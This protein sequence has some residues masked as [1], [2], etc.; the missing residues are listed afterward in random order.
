M[1]KKNTYIIISIIIMIIGIIMPISTNIYKSANLEYTTANYNTTPIGEIVKD[2]TVK[3][4]IEV[5]ERLKKYG[6][7]FAT[8]ARKNS[9][10]IKITLNQ[11]ENIIEEIV[12]ISKIKDNSTYYLKSD[13]SKLHKGKAIIEIRGIDG[14]EGNAVTIYKSEDISLGKLSF[15]G[16]E[17]NNGIVQS[18]K[19][20][21]IDKNTI[22][23]IVFAV[24]CIMCCFYIIYLCNANKKTNKLF[25]LTAICIFC[26]L[27]IKIPIL[28]FNCEPYA[29]IVTNFYINGTTKDIL[30]N[31]FI[32]DAGYLPLF[33]RIISLII[34]KVLRLSPSHTIYL[35]QNFAIIAISL[36]SSMFTLKYYEKYGDILFRFSI[37]IIIG[38]CALVNYY[39][40]HS[41]IN[42]SYYGI[43]F[44][45]LISLLDLNNIE[46]KKYILVIVLTAL[47]SISK[48]HYVV[49]L[50]IVVFVLIWKRGRISNRYKLFLLDIFLANVIQL[51]YTY[52]NLNMWVKPNTN[53]I[54]ISIIDIINN[55]VHQVVQQL[56][57]IFYPNIA[58]INNIIEM[59]LTFLVILV[60]F[61]L[62]TLCLCIKF[63]K[64]ESA[65][66]ISLMLMIFGTTMF[67]VVT[68]IWGGAN[69]ANQYGAI[70]TRHAFFIEIS[71]L[72][73]I[74]LI[75][76][77]IKLLL[78]SK[79]TIK[80]N[81]TTKV[82]YS[83]LALIIMVRYVTFD[84]SSIET[85]SMSFSDWKVYSKFYN[86]DSY[87][88]PI[89]PVG[90]VINK[91]CEVYLI[92]REQVINNK[93]IDQMITDN[94]NQVHELN[95]GSSKKIKYL[96]TKR[97][98]PYNQNKIILKGY[99]EN[100][101]EILDATQLNDMDRMYIG[102][103][104]NIDKEI[105]TIK[106]FNE[107]MSEAYVLP[108][109]IIGY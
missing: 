105:K 50:P 104:A 14:S 96:Y 11:D 58:N 21:N 65:V 77:F 49:L 12:D 82:I 100:N 94:V 89:N 54:S 90:W 41:F 39:D 88:I 19:S 55:T 38:S 40:S 22:F 71:I 9:G 15:N 53:S 57:N 16:I 86:E 23:K 73:I 48:S 80:D 2:V 10:N 79:Y 66:L 93:P 3:Q 7:S 87:L 44:I 47:L 76:Y 107:D 103:K 33:Q 106:F 25:I 64:K 84:N 74:V 28:S 97:I 95:I 31:V 98:R 56:I 8:Y 27:N 78:N 18:F 24:I 36:I 1:N 43:V 92:S 63:K 60:V 20:I 91:N 35:M 4:E 51:V 32:T 13:I 69:W 5:P 85:T 83:F 30:N 42:F 59:N 70:L 61:I 26:I 102:F 45:I 46:K 72:F 17:E 81:K 101:N 67:N 108:E 68:N 109:I 52:R 75:L 34:I 6:I 62:I 29:E 99:D 37:S